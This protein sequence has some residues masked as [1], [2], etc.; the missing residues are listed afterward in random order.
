MDSTWYIP[1]TCYADTEITEAGLHVGRLAVTLHCITT[2]ILDLHP[3]TI[4][5]R[6]LNR[7]FDIVTIL[8]IL[9]MV[10]NGAELVGDV[11]QRSKYWVT[12]SAIQQRN[13]SRLI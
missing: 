4:D 6:T 9:V 7:L 2:R 10:V 1:L 8:V 12:E 3:Q 5:L 11:D 13:K